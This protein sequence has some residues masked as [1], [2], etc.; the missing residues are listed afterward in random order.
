M[1]VQLLDLFAFMS[2]LL[3]AFT[4]AFEALAVGGVFFRMAIARESKLLDSRVI[5]FVTWFAVLL[6]AT[7]AAYVAANSALLMESTGLTWPEVRGAAFCISGF[8]MMGGALGIAIFARSRLA[9]WLCPIGAF[10]ILAGAVMSSH[11]MARL[12]HRWELAVLTVAHHAAGAAWIGGFPYLLLSLRRSDPAI[13][14][15]IVARFSRMA[16]IAVPVLVLAGLGMS[17][18][19][20]G[21]TAALTGT[22]YGI[23]LSSKAIMTVGLLLLGALNLRIVR[24]VRAGSTQSLLPLRRFA[25]AELGIGITILL[26][27]ASLTSSAPAVDVQQDRVTPKE[28][29]ERMAPK[30]PRLQTPPLSDLSP[31]TPLIPLSTPA[32]FV[33]GQTPQQ[34]S[35]PGDIAWSEYN[36]NWAGLIVFAIG[37]LSLLARRWSLARNWPLIFLGLAVFLLV[38][39]DPENW[40]LGPRS[41]W[42]SFR[43]AEVAQHR[44]FVLL[45]VFFAAF[46][47]CV[48]NGKV[49]PARAGLV[50]PLVCAVGGALLLTHSHSLGN[51]KEEFLAELSHTPIAILA[52]FAGWSRW[53]EVRHNPRYVRWI[54][55]VCFILIGAILMDYRE[56]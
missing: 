36:H 5:G 15:T 30:W 35:K 16:T 49:N 39:A 50:F 40:P 10:A 28:I 2:V 32:S 23:M 6:A 21:S 53:L 26:A 8:L 55:P 51:V 3:R 11:S 37:L 56:A 42:A 27:A 44:L 29:A 31:P 46:E 4:L 48:Q 43:V 17:L 7:Q 19:Y 38:R 52:V 9:R 18:A 25:E 47:W 24:A 34:P 12:D 45:I 22:A 41:F 54:W 33:P 13:A 20:V 14:A 1:L